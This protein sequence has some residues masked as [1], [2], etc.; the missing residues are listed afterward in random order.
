[1]V[2][3]E[4]T[5]SGLRNVFIKIKIAGKNPPSPP[6]KKKSLAREVAVQICRICCSGLDPH[7][8]WP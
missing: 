4:R 3:P 6:P 7:Y 2:S 1:M 5:A 8:P